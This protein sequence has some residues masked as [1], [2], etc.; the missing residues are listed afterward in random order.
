MTTRGRIF[1][2]D[3]SPRWLDAKQAWGM[4]MYNLGR[5]DEHPQMRRFSFVEKAEY[6]AL[7]WGTVVMVGTGWVMWFEKFVSL[8]GKGVIEVLLVIHYYEAW[9]AF[10]AIVVWHMY[11]VVFNPHV[12]PMNPSW[13]TV[14]CP[15]T[16]SKRNIR[17]P[18]LPATWTRSNDWVWSGTS[19]S[20]Y[21]YLYLVASPSGEAFFYSEIPRKTF[22]FFGRS[23]S[24]N[25]FFGRKGKGTGGIHFS[26]G[27]EKMPFMEQ[28][29]FGVNL[30]E[31]KP[32]KAI[33]AR[34]PGNGSGSFGRNCPVVR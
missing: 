9:L 29:L 3:I 27:V 30:K 2:K 5:T 6:W 28:L 18:S 16:C 7:I 21:R 26:C 24:G 13:L 17:R 31:D 25:G 12:Y 14:R 23:G 22:H 20:P 4:I 19:D 15:R 34:S 32:K 33:L 8:M 1:L 10:L 11:G